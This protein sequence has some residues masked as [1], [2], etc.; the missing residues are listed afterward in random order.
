MRYLLDGGAWIAI[1]PSGTEPKLKVYI[2]ANAEK[3]N[4][5]K[6]LLDKLMSDADALL[7]SLL[8]A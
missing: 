5:V 6:E 2:G 3:E 4:E 8:Y 1:R 7:K